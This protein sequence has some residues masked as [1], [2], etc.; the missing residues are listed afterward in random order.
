MNASTMRRPLCA[1]A[2]LSLALPTALQ[3]QTTSDGPWAK[4]PPLSTACYYE[5]D[6]GDAKLAAAR[7]AV[8]ADH[9]KQRAINDRI[10][11]QKEN[12][13]PMEMAQRLQE[14]MM[15]DPQNARKY[16]EAMQSMAD[17]MPTEAPEILE[18]EK[19]MQAE[20][21]ALMKRYQAALKQA[22]GPANARWGALK[23]KLGIGP[24]S[25]HPGEA[26]VPDWAWTEWFEIQREWDRAYVA[27]CAQ[28]WGAGGQAQAFMKRYK[29]W[30]VQERIPH[31]EGIDRQT[32]ATFTMMGLGAYQSEA[33]FDGVEDYIK[34]A[35]GLWGHRKPLPRCPGGT[36]DPNRLNFAE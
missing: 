12:N 32:A 17:S 11:A 25:T 20:S 15:K 5:Q 2:F 1:A 6:P 22:Y 33:A 28:W 23:K 30:L 34:L 19:Q 14:A 18:K 8:R 24:D 13:D 3:A 7:D 4:V 9:A 31:Y 26:G 21:E 10:K 27:N 36:C 35:Q 29:D 16:M